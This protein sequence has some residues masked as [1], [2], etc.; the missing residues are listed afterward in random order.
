[1]A[2][3]YY[4]KCRQAYRQ[5]VTA[6]A[7]EVKALKAEGKIDVLNGWRYAAL[8]PKTAWSFDDVG[9]EAG[10]SEKISK[11]IAGVTA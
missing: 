2:A 8:G 7:K 3:D 6:W 10:I 11:M 9:F 4:L 5:K 1:V